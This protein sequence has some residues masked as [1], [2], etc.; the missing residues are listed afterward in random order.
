MRCQTESMDKET[1]QKFVNES[2]ALLNGLP[3]LSGDSARVAHRLSVAVGLLENELADNELVSPID[4][5]PGSH[6]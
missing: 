2:R 6:D 1:V 3:A 5:L 4:A